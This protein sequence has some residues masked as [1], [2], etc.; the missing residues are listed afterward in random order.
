M[1]AEETMQT[2]EIRLPAVPERHLKVTPL[3]LRQ[4]RFKTAMRG[5][6]KA[7]VMALLEEIASD[8]ENALRE[9]DRMRHELVRL[10]ASLSQHRELEGSLKTTLMSAQRVADDMRTNANQD[11]ARIVREA[12]GRAE[13]LIQK[14]QAQVEDIHRE[15]DSLRLKR[16]EAETSIESVIATLH[17]TLAFVREQQREDKVVPHR[18]RVELAARPA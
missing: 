12:E 18:P 7:E 8:Y 5:F 14:T 9:N 1:M 11:A 13:L 4:P 15:I 3:D 2:A 16:R 10:E 6:D 17:H